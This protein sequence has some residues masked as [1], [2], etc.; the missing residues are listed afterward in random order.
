MTATSHHYENLSRAAVACGRC[1]AQSSVVNSIL[2]ACTVASLAVTSSERR[3]PLGCV[4]DGGNGAGSVLIS[5]T[6]R[7]V[8]THASFACLANTDTKAFAARAI[9]DACCDN[10]GGY[11][12]E[13]EQTGEGY[14]SLN[15]VLSS[16]ATASMDACWFGEC[17][18]PVP[19]YPAPGNSGY[20][21]AE[22]RCPPTPYLQTTTAES[23]SSLGL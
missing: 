10:S 12:S 13:S 4:I 23:K 7:F 2:V 22:I 1:F 18:V 8:D 21:F 15:G 9:G 5:A 11:D 14:V 17:T 6:W 20:A 3:V 16:T 19:P